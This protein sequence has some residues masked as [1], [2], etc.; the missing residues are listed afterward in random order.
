M[1]A[2]AL[3]RD[4]V[5][6]NTVNWEGDGDPIALFGEDVTPVNIE[7]NRV[8]TMGY[9]YKDGVFTAP[10]PTQ[11]SIDEKL[12]Q[13]KRNN[14]NSRIYLLQ[15]AR[16]IIGILQ[17][18]VDLDLAINNEAEDLITWKKYRISIYRIDANTTDEIVFP[19][20]PS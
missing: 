4:G 12:A 5:V 20:Q 17:D 3:V 1:A 6:F 8:V 9:T 11:E 15:Q 7:D 2:Y 16:D 13:Q 14:I 10:P 18:A 19:D